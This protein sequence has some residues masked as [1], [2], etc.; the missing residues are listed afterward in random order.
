VVVKVGPLKVKTCDRRQGAGGGRAL[1][2]AWPPSSRCAPTLYG[3]GPLPP[4]TTTGII[5]GAQ[6]AEPVGVNRCAPTIWIQVGPERINSHHRP[7]TRAP[8][9]PT[10]AAGIP[11]GCGPGLGPGARWPFR[12][13]AGLVPGGPPVSPGPG[14]HNYFPGVAFFTCGPC[15]RFVLFLQ[16]PVGTT[17]GPTVSTT[18]PKGAQHA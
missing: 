5:D 11:S 7:G 2:R 6:K 1:P 8:P 14:G 13:M 18:N 3:Q 10:Q 15:K 17:N 9:V 16:G 12:A 4:P